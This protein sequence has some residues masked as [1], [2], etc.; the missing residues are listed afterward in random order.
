M[1]T[2]HAKPQPHS[3]LSESDMC[4]HVAVGERKREE[5]KQVKHVTSREFGRK[6]KCTVFIVITLASKSKKFLNWKFSRLHFH[7]GIVAGA[8]VQEEEGSEQ[9]RTLGSAE[10]SGRWLVGWLGDWPSSPFLAASAVAAFGTQE[11]GSGAEEGGCLIN[12]IFLT[13]Y[14]VLKTSN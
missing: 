14:V 2:K 3:L 13:T 9:Q 11:D 5:S 6:K 10:R 12:I 1:F 7:Y 4:V 8:K